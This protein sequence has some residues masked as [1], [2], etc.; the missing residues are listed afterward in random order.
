MVFSPSSATDLALLPFL[1][2]RLD[3]TCLYTVFTQ[4]KT[5]ISIDS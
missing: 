1:S 5:A 2:A 3:D 4:L